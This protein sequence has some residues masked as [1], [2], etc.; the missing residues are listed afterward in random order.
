MRVVRFYV[1]SV[2]LILI[3]FLFLFLVLLLVSV[4]CRIS[5]AIVWVQC[6]VPDLNRDPARAVFWPDLNR[7]PVSSVF[8][9]RPQPRSCEISVPRR[10]ST[11]ILLDECSAPDR[12]RDPF[13]KNVRRYVRKNVRRYVRKNVG[14]NVR[15]NVRRYVKKNLGKNV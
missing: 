6:S 14:R 3:L 10:T 12:K 15:I 2:L 8:R 1:S 11:A 7:D 9:A 13:R 5:T 4:L